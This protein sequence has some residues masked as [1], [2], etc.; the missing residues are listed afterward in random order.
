[1]T[2]EAKRCVEALRICHSNEDCRD[3][4]FVDSDKD[5]MS[6][7]N[8]LFVEAADLIKSLSAKL[9]ATEAIAAL[10]R[11]LE[12]ERDQLKARLEHVEF[13][14]DAAVMDLNMV[15][16]C[17]VC[18]RSCKYDKPNPYCECADFEWRGAREELK[19]EL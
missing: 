18:S 19:G 8:V 14:R 4:K 10:A 9:E 5:E 2:D 11:G 15:C 7:V 6:C 3:C 17:D 13:E 16:M 12:C 1:M